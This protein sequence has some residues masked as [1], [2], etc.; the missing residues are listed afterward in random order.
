[1][2]SRQERVRALGIIGSPRRGGNTEILVD[3]A[4]AGAAEAGASIDKVFLNDLDIAP[5]QACDACRETRV[6]A[7]Q[8][9]MQAVVEKM[10]GG[11]VFVFGT[12]VYWY[13]PTAQFK[14][15]MDRWYGI[16]K[17]PFRGKRVLLVM[18]LG[19]VAHVARHAVGMITD[20]LTWAEA[21]L[22]ETILAPGAYD[23]GEVRQFSDVLAAARRAGRKAAETR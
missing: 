6:C 7:Q 20:S 17:E 22:V 2:A 12:P 18:P 13:G 9:D 5:C 23:L 1:M 15:F 19:D 14:A 4:L 11:T 21:E 16:G 3:E 10:R 8:D